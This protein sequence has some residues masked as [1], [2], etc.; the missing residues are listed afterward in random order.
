MSKNEADNTNKISVSFLKKHDYFTGWHSGTI[1][2]TRNGWGEEHKSSVGVEVSIM[3]GNNY[4][5]IHY[6]QTKHDTGE[7]KDFDYKIPLET[8]PCR[9]GGKRYWF[10]CPWYKD[11]TYCG[12]RV[13]T[14]YK[15]GDYFAC[16]HCYDLT[17]SSRKVNRRYSMFPLF[18]TLILEQKMEKLEQE[19]KRPY[20][21]GKP[22]RKQKRLENLQGQLFKSYEQYTRNKGENMLY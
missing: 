9:Y 16:R 12:K 11:G 6:T 3:N 8:T 1:T 21:Q 20:Y 22:T 18:G 13:G 7:K 10:I 14:L 19:I 15:D 17:Y 4:L 5:R 2:W